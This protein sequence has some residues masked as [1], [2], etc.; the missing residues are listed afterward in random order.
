MSSVRL[1]LGCREQL[2]QLAEL[3]QGSVV[4]SETCRAFQV[5]DDRIEWALLVIG[6]AE[7]PK[8]PALSA[9]GF[10]ASAP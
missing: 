1:E 3:V 9:T 5:G 6:R 4:A 2:L 7:I 8:P 10:N